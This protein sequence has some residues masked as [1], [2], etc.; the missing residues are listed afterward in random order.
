MIRECVR[1]GF[2]MF[3][4]QVRAGERIERGARTVAISA[5]PAVDIHFGHRRA[6]IN[7]DISEKTKSC[8]D[9]DPGRSR[10]AWYRSARCG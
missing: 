6:D 2:D 1:I 4:R 9:R 8:A 10:E 5:I 3:E 7:A